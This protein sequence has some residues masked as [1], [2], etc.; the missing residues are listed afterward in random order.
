MGNALLRRNV[1][2]IKKNVMNNNVN[3]NIARIGCITE[4]DFFFR[5]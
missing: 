2:F 3:N 4:I 5:I 1:L